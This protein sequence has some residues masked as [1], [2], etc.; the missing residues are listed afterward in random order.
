MIHL[1][2]ISGMLGRLTSGGPGRTQVPDMIDSFD[3]R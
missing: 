2:A 1:A 3:Q